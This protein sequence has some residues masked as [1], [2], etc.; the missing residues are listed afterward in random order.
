MV[1]S[2][3]TMR[4]RSSLVT[5]LRWVLMVCI[6]PLVIA[7]DV[8]AVGDANALG[9]CPD[10]VWEP[11]MILGSDPGSAASGTERLIPDEM[12]GTPIRVLQYNVQFLFPEMAL[13]FVSLDEFGHWPSTAE[14]AHAIGEAIARGCYDIIA[15]NESVNDERREDIIAAIEEG[16]RACG[17][18]SDSA[19]PGRLYT[20]QGPKLGGLFVFSVVDDLIELIR[21]G[22]DAGVDDALVDDELTLIS[23]FPIVETNALVFSESAAIDTA[24]AKGVLH[25]RVWRGGDY[26]AYDVIDVYATHLQ[27]GD[28]PDVRR[29]QLEELAAFIHATSPSSI[30]ILILGDFNIDGLEDAQHG[31]PD[32]YDDLMEIL[33]T[34]LVVDD[35][36]RDLVTGTNQS[37]TR[38]IDYIL[39]SSNVLEVHDVGVERF[40]CDD[41]S[42]SF[43]GEELPTL[44]DHAAVAADLL[45]RYIAPM[46][47]HV[48]RSR[49]RVE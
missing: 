49:E 41:L 22:E 31:R 4:N 44:S 28:F 43:C 23:R 16:S 8:P 13:R 35:I 29:S 40:A 1:S 12:G 46:D 21:H 37:G 17:E 36:G 7:Q 2:I 5:T 38:R 33:G 14:R 24:A 42:L 26:H 30:P 18:R 10:F 20:V 34:H 11:H 48:C 9:V 45:W 6:L 25:A 47:E 3:F 39:L 27:A 19:T 32:A 15:L